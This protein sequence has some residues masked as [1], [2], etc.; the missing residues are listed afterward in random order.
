MPAATWAT[1]RRRRV[2]HIRYLNVFKRPVLFW[3]HDTSAG[4]AKTYRLIDSTVPLVDRLISLSRLRVLR[5]VS[6]QVIA[7][8][9]GRL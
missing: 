3:V 1:R 4:C 2:S 9:D 6:R 7:I 5:P 8:V